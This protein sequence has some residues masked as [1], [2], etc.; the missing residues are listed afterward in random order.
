MR[1]I[2][3]GTSMHIEGFGRD[4]KREIKRRYPTPVSF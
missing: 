1:E 3:P 2:F 4:F